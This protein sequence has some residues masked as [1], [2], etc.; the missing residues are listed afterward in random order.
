[1]RSAFIAATAGM[2]LSAVTLAACSSGTS[3]LSTG[4]TTPA[5]AAG[6]KPATPQERATHA[7]STVGKAAGC[8]YN[9][10]PAR[11][12]A[13]YLAWEG[14]QGTAPADLAALEKVYDSTRSRAQAAIS[15]PEEF[16]DEA[17]T[18]KIK[19]DLTKQLAGDFSA[20]VKPAEIPWWKSTSS[21][22]GKLDR[23]KIFNPQVK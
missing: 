16:C 19:R 1:M 15:K 23:D 17:Q 22:P 2:L 4:S 3:L 20:P 5:N 10:D 18:E 7:G 21:G 8:G 12:R 11:L 13:G 9:F 14:Q 6:P